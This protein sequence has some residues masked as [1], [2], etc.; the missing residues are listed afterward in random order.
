MS[1]PSFNDAIE[2][3]RKYCAYQD[4]AHSEV[5]TKLIAIKIYG[6]ELEEV[7]AQLISEG[8][9]NEERYARSFVR[10][11]FK[12]NKW[13]RF[14]IE[15]HLKQKGVSEYCIRKGMEEID[16]ELYVACIDGLIKR[17]FSSDLDAAG[18]QKIVNS[19][20]RKGFEPHLIKDRIDHLARQVD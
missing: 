10:G 6:D 18:R 15:Q 19:L 16:N 14:K 17:Q 3:M 12:M 7:M 1:A 9:L 20:M 2:K 4:R 5:R 13:G 8:F 11:K